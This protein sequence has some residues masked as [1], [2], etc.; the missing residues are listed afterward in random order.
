VRNIPTITGPTLICYGSPTNILSAI[1]PTAYAPWT[2]VPSG[3][4]V[5]IYRINNNHEVMLSLLPWGAYYELQY[6]ARN[7]CGCGPVA[8]KEI[9]AVQYN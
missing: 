8:V 2:V 9:W 7:A 5:N 6:Q 3:Q 1:S 4:A